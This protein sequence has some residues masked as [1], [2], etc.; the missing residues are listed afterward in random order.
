MCEKTAHVRAI[1]FNISFK[2]TVDPNRDI[3]ANNAE[4]FEIATDF[5][6]QANSASAT[7]AASNTEL[8]SLLGGFE[9]AHGEVNNTRDEL[10]AV[11]EK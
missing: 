7:V 3:P 8:S 10:A 9:K 5:L 2:R 11:I 6:N 1:I 4:F